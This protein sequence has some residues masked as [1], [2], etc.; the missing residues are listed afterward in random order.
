VAEFK[1]ECYVSCMT[2][3][4]EFPVQEQFRFSRTSSTLFAESNGTLHDELDPQE[5]ERRDAQ[6]QSTGAGSHYS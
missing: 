1:G 5:E 6:V 3:E 2:C 4:P